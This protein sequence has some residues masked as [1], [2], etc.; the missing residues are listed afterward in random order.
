MGH[1]HGGAHAGLSL[2][3]RAGLG[4]GRLWGVSLRGGAQSTAGAP[5]NLTKVIFLIS[6][7]VAALFN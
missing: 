3:Q 1:E 7:G 5:W 4:M 6:E 2:W